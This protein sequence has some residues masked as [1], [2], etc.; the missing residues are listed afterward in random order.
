MHEATLVGPYLAMLGMM[1]FNF[2]ASMRMHYPVERK[3]ELSALANRLWEIQKELL[4]K[5]RLSTKGMP[6]RGPAY[7]QGI[8]ETVYKVRDRV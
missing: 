6:P 1:P 2:Y 8:N 7:P 3:D 5:D 4:V